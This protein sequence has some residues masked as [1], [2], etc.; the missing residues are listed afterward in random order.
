MHDDPLSELLALL[1][2]DFC[3]RSVRRIDADGWDGVIVGG[4]G[5]LTSCPACRWEF[6]GQ[7]ATHLEEGRSVE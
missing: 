3:N 6:L 2:C 5:T 1:V 4:E 7:V